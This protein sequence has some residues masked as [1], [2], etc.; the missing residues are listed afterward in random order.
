MPAACLLR[1]PLPR[2]MGWLLVWAGLL[3]GMAARASEYRQLP[4]ASPTDF[5]PIG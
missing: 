1:L 3:L 4:P 5:R 2:P